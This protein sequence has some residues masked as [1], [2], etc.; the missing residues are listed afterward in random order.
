MNF[1]ESSSWI[2]SSSLVVIPI[3]VLTLVILL[4]IRKTV[5]LASLRRHHDVAGYMFSI[6]GVLYSVILGFTV[7]NVQERYNKADETVDIEAT[8]IADLYRDAAYFDRASLA[9]IRTNL[10]KYVE[11][12]IHNEWSKPSDQTRRI[13]AN[14]YLQAI[15]K[16]YE[17]VDIMQ[18]ERS[19]IWYE[20]TIV[21]LDRLMNARL[22]REFYSWEHLSSMMWSIL[23]LGAVIT[24]SF[25]F[26]FGLENLRIQMLMT[27]LLTIYLTFMLYLVFS[28]D[29]VFQGPVHV[30][31]KAF[32]G[33][34]RHLRSF[35]SAERLTM[36]KGGIFCQ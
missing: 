36:S 7:I 8:M 11:Y 3:T 1:Y 19:K 4:F 17:S 33:D 2:L 32:E 29:H 6:I 34:T 23:I 15:W 5:S 35:G 12:V 24:I 14:A 10:R 20:Q 13:Q 28:L 31:P 30:T 27:A 16:S 26:F 9:S 22:A 25:M 21:K 18:N